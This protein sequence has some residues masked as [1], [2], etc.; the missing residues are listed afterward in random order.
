MRFALLLPW[1]FCALPDTL[2]CP[3]GQL[4]LPLPQGFAVGGVEPDEMGIG[5]IAAV[6]KLLERHGLTVDDIDLWELNEAFAVVPLRCAD[7]L[8]IDHDKMNVNGGSIS[9]GHPFG[10]TGSRMVGHVLMEGKRRGAKQVVVT[11]C[12]GETPL[13]ATL[14][15]RPLP[16]ALCTGTLCRHPLQPQ[17]HIC[18]PDRRRQ[19]TRD[20]ERSCQAAAWVPP[21][22]SRFCRA[23]GPT[24][25][26]RSGSRGAVLCRGRSLATGST[27]PQCSSASP[28]PASRVT[29]GEGH[30]DLSCGTA[31]PGAIAIATRAGRNNGR[32]AAKPCLPRYM[33][34][35]SHSQRCSARR[36]DCSAD[37]R[38]PWAAASPDTGISMVLAL[39]P[40][41]VAVTLMLVG[42]GPLSLVTTVV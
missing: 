32:L 1:E 24:R 2:L 12:I 17:H 4:T 11:M 20:M 31:R 3:G 8:G 5:P 39:S 10:M 27:T 22:C 40:G 13:P 41:E 18:A 38:T 26:R 30:R 35:P 42:G 37:A 36:S 19:L 34:A 21:A 33:G 14:C 15:S 6:P 28:A 7:V 9:V 29:R 16:A 25:G 23:G